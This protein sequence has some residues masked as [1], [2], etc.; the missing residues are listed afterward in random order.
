MTSF[1]ASSHYQCAPQCG[2]IIDFSPGTPVSHIQGKI[3]NFIQKIEILM[4]GFGNVDV[5]SHMFLKPS[6]LQILF[7]T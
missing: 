5:M 4:D 3:G 1:V 2:S 7:F 6:Q